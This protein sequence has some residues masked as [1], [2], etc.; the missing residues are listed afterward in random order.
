MSV[1]Q[2]KAREKSKEPSQQVKSMCKSSK[3]RI[4]SPEESVRLE[5]AQRVRRSMVSEDSDAEERWRA[6]HAALLARVSDSG[7]CPKSNQKPLKGF[8]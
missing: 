4:Q 3:G 5:R 2:P 8:K 6:A 1:R 7:L